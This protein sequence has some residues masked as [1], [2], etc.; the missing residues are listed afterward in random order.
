MSKNFRYLAFFFV[1]F[2]FT[3]CSFDK[4]TGIW[5]GHENEKKRASDLEKE[6]N[7]V[8]EIY[9]SEQIYSTEINPD[10]SN[11][12]SP[13]KNNSSWKMSGL[14]LQNQTGNLYLSGANDKFLKKKIGKNKFSVLKIK[15]SA[16]FILSACSLACLSDF[17]LA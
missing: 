1:V 9:S 3:G 10:K 2:F 8:I 15:P 14:N 6:Q 13:P 16:I 12:L 7:E 4:K 11:K 5:S 17:S